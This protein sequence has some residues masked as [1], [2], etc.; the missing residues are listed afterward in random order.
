MAILVCSL[1][2]VP[3]VIAARQPSQVV[4]LL[5][6]ET[7]FPETGPNY[8]DRH[9]R[10][11]LHDIV[12]DEEGATAPAPAHVEALVD[13]LNQWDPARGPLLIHCYAGI[14]RST[15]SA[16]I[17][18]CL[19]NPGVDEDVIASALRAASPTATPNRRIIALADALMG[20][21][22]R[23]RA[24]IDRIGRGAAWHEIGEAQPFEIPARY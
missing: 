22:G 23:M 24:A 14:S 4:S 18:A 12:A 21:R 19:H 6:P 2:R 9:L 15:A 11:S 17:T 7:P 10:L 8:I 5:D 3:A 13:F 20:R 1:S 16:F